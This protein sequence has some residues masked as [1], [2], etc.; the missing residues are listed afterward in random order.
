MAP[1]QRVTLTRGTFTIEWGQEAVPRRA[2]Q[3]CPA[4]WAQTRFP[5]P[6]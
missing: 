5:P 4:L 6:V 1:V 3:R 2:L